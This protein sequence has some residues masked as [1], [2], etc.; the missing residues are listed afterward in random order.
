[1]L[2]YSM[3]KHPIKPIVM[4]AYATLLSSIFAFVTALIFEPV[5]IRSSMSEAFWPTASLVLYMVLASNVFNRTLYAYLIRHYSATF[6][7]YSAFLGPIITAIL[8]WF[9]LGEKISWQFYL[10][11]LII[12]CGIYLFQK[13]EYKSKA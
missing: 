5:W 11:G 4:N 3:H 1:M 8:G 10:A 7:A 6:M 12:F 13:D 9:L 2:K